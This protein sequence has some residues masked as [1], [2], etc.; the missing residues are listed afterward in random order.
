[1]ARQPYRAPERGVR[2]HWGVDFLDARP[3]I[4]R[5]IGRCVLSW[6]R[7]EYLSA[8]FLGVLLE[9]KTP[10]AMSVYL[11]LRRSTNRVAAITAATQ[12][13]EARDSELC[14]A[15]LRVIQSAE[16]ER[17]SFVHGLFGVTDDL[18]DDVLW[19][20]SQNLSAAAVNIFSFGAM[21]EDIAQGIIDNAFIYTS[22]D[23]LA[24]EAQINDAVRVLMMAMQYIGLKRN[25]PSFARSE[26]EERYSQLCSLAPMQEA[27]LVL[28]ARAQKHTQ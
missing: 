15:V 21:E 27:L 19:T 7:V 18:P 20:E 11:T 23:I 13:L 22:K 12:H 24:I 9:S 16:A 17:N 28:R 2:V 3:E 25:A 14:A 4:V 26:V 6:T 5:L 8:A 10:A 1:M